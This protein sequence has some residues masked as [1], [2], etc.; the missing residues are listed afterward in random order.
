MRY[1]FPNPIPPPYEV[2]TGYMS[3][4]E[5]PTDNIKELAIIKRFIKSNKWGHYTINLFSMLYNSKDYCWV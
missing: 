1:M 4:W 3:P 2:S 5:R